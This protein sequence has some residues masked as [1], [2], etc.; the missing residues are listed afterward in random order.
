M[1]GG[2]AVTNHPPLVAVLIVA[3]SLA[4]LAACG[5]KPPPTLSTRL[6]EQARDVALDDPLEVTVTGAALDRVVVERLDAPG[7]GPAVE[8]GPTR[9]R[10]TGQLEPDAR[11][12][13]VA[14]AHVLSDAV[15]PP[16]EA[17]ERT[18]LTLQREFSTVRSPALIEPT[19][20]VVL[21]RGKPL[22][23]RFSEPLADARL[24]EG[25]ATA[26]GHLASNDPRLFRVDFAQLAPGQEMTLKI[27]GLRAR[28]GAPG[29]DQAL[30]V[31][32]PPAVELQTINGIEPADRVVVPPQTAVALEWNAPVTAVQ[33]RVG[34]KTERW[35]G[36]P[37]ERVSLPVTLEQGQASTLE[38]LDATGADGGWLAA[39]RGVELAAPPP[40]RV[41]AVWPDT[42]AT[43]V[44]PKADPHFRF[45]EPVASREAAEKLITFDPPVDG[46]WEWLS[47]E[48]VRFVPE[49]HFARESQINVQIQGGPSGILS[50][51]GTYLTDS[52]TT[53]FQTGKLKT[54]RV[55]LG[56]Q[57]LALLEEDQEIWSAP[58]ATGVRGAETP[59]GV[60]E[61]QYKMPVARF[62]G[63]NPGGSRYD[64]PDVKWVLA[65]YGDYTIHGA[66]WRS[67]FGAPASN[68]CVSLT[69]ANAKV[70]YD[71]A[72]PGT[73]VEILR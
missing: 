51:S 4:T 44:S 55:W 10:L 26:R 1:R 59:P 56:S 68:G 35:S 3:L 31:R 24:V 54:I 63:V 49:T 40:L 62:R 33:Y 11:Y 42:G 61:V 48:R 69:D 18:D 16:W 58:V 43:N 30:S 70:V 53:S 28:N 71:F 12:R 14:E 36:Q 50:T 21:Q 22:D 7:A 41:A 19:E 46:R 25:P 29:A 39:I 73:R 13:L 20:A 2:S 72:D 8:M 37:S 64:I 32:T 60:Y 17:P 57:R 47:P 5:S 34:D 66:Y 9:A 6:P 27:A 38:L 52:V 15:R 67:R 45:S 65:F 23:V